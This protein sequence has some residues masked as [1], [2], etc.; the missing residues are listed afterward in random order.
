MLVPLPLDE[1]FDYALDGAPPP[2]GSFV[3][4]PFGPR[5]LVGVVWPGR[6]GREVARARLKPVGR[7]LDVPPLPPAL[8]RLVEHVAA[9]TLAPLGNALKLAIP[10]PAALDPP[11]PRPGLRRAPAPPDGV[12]LTGAR[13]RV[14]EALAE[15]EVVAAADL[16]RRAG[17]S[18]AVIQGLVKAGLLES[19]PMPPADPEQPDPGRPA[20][21]LSPVQEEVGAALRARVGGGH[22][23]VLLEGVPGA[24]KTEVYLEAVAEALRQ[25]RQALVLLPEIALSAQLLGRFRRR[26][27]VEPAVW[28]SELGSAPRRRTWRA[29]AEGKAP[30]V[31]G[32]RS[33]LL[34]PLGRLGVIVVVEEHDQSF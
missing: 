19:A 6:G 8:L 27:G 32:A 30:I 34:L 2:P 18:P 25:G 10:V 21:D 3:E 17:A 22:G 4:V 5:D 14:L 13:S 24:G 23:V 12:R 26:F 16:G 28:H 7:R 15:G 31:I 20:V 29:I 9:I 11:L 33:A 1:P